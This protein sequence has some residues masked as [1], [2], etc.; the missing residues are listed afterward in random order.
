MELHHRDGG[1]PGLDQ[2]AEY[3]EGEGDTDVCYSATE[4]FDKTGTEKT[5]GE[6]EA[7]RTCGI[8]SGTFIAV[9]PLILKVSG[10][11]GNG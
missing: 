2:P 8:F 3:G 10:F 11:S 6:A 7:G 5:G 4:S 9:L 1:L